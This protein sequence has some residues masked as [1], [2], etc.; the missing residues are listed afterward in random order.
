MVWL[1][2]VSLYDEFDPI[3]YPW[4]EIE[5]RLFDADPPTDGAWGTLR[6]TQVL[7]EE[8]ES[9]LARERS[10]VFPPPTRR[11]ESRSRVGFASGL[12]LLCSLQ[13]LSRGHAYVVRT[14][15]RHRLLDR[16][17]SLG[18]GDGLR[19]LGKHEL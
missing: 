5:T 19:L 17:V 18:V 14:G 6:K 13:A 16:L 1:D 9:R 12:P 2:A 11:R 15:R 7:L 4:T 3:D 10:G 8:A